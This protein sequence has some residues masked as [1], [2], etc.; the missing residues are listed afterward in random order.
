MRH[1]RKACPDGEMDDVE[2]GYNTPQAINLG[3][4]PINFGENE[5]DEGY[6]EGGRESRDERVGFDIELC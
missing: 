2:V 4:I 5:T 1:T 3:E 6:S